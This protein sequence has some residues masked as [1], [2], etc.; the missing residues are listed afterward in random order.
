[1]EL[2][3]PGY[4][5]LIP[6]RGDFTMAAQW[7]LS[8]EVAKAS[9]NFQ[10][11]DFSDLLLLHG[12]PMMAAPCSSNGEAVKASSNNQN[13]TFLISTPL[14]QRT[15]LAKRLTNSPSTDWTEEM[16]FSGVLNRTIRC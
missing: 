16:T 3:F 5:D 4:D 9:S 7:R 12:D 8:D 2:Q 15:Y 6:T 10:K 13:W 14:P 11:T 1:M